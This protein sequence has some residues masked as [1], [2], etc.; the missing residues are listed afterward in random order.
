MNI[1]QAR[2]DASRQVRESGR[3]VGIW[4][5]VGLPVAD[6]YQTRPRHRPD[7]TSEAWALVESADPAGE[8][9]VV[10]VKLT[11]GWKVE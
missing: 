6:D 10:F 4:R 1:F 11:D 7:L 8:D 5:Y 2:M 9:E 3:S